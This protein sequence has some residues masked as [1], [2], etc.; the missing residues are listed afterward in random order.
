M[1]TKRPVASASPE[2][3]WV[4]FTNFCIIGIGIILLIL[5][6]LLVARQTINETATALGGPDFT[7]ASLGSGTLLG[8]T[9][10]DDGNS[11]T[12]D[13]S[14]SI[15]GTTVCQNFPLP[16]NTS[17]G[18]QCLVPTSGACVGGECRGLCNG[19]CPFY[20]D[21]DPLDCPEI[22][23]LP[24]ITEAIDDEDLFFGPLCYYGKCL[25]I[26][27]YPVVPAF[28]CSFADSLDVELD[29]IPNTPQG[30]SLLDP[31]DLSS[32]CFT[33]ATL[34]IGGEIPVY[35]Y[36]YEC[37]GYDIFAP[38][39]PIVPGDAVTNVEHAEIDAASNEID[40]KEGSKTLPESEALESSKS[41]LML[42]AK[43]KTK[44]GAK[45]T[46]QKTKGEKTIMKPKAFGA[47]AMGIN[48]TKVRQAYLDAVQSRKV[49]KQIPKARV[50]AKR[51]VPDPIAM[52]DLSVV[53][54]QALVFSA[55]GGDTLGQF[56]AGT[57]SSFE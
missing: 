10:C 29:Y 34:C 18:Q 25:Y 44:V 51:Q 7:P 26:L 1:N 19:Y 52:G 57:V 30:L 48:P 35:I 6:G 8:S 22:N 12:Q 24:S 40:T 54:A 16:T 55:L 38:D 3:S 15:S 31:S 4:L 42:K 23:F 56:I 11:C 21:F 43:N 41:T 9:A 2:S 20:I 33:A 50:S 47:G 32:T 14:Y 39:A 5:V 13:F 45:K 37:S 49:A 28:I 53:E 17:C 36:Q 27:E 46:H